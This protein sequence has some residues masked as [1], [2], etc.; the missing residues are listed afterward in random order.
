MP[1]ISIELGHKHLYTSCNLYEN[2]T[3]DTLNLY[4]SY[5]KCFLVNITYDIVSEHLYY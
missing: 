3:C 5:C 1:S 4:L 2:I